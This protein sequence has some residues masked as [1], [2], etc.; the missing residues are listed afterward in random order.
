M[1][2]GAH[3]SIAGGL[4]RAIH[5]GEEAGCEAVQIFTKNST[6][7]AAKPLSRE[8]AENFR[9]TL[10]TSKVSVVFV[11]DSYLINLGSPKKADRKK[12]IDAFLE[13]MRR[14][15]SL[16]LP[17][18]V[19]HPG[20]HLGSG[21][22]E[23]LQRIAESLNILLDRTKRFRMKVLLETTA[24]QGTTLGYRFEHL[25]KLLELAEQP[26]RVGICFDTCHVFAAGYDIRTPKGYEKVMDEFD[27]VVGLSHIKA[28]HLNDCKKD[29]GCRVDRHEHIG[30]GFIG[31]GGF[32]SLMRDRRFETIPMVLETPKGPDMKEDK[33]NLKLLRSLASGSRQ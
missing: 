9:E 27:A 11:H 1:I 28:F 4:D 19:A 32:R 26:A 7:W 29:L 20:A 17:Y 10:R 15:E 31:I 5:R 6:Q 25:G 23:G 30:K 12:S 14:V 13:E 3:M 18:L 21:E 16:G 22:S 8:N 33:Q 2:L 24:G